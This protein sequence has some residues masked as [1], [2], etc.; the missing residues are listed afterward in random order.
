[1]LTLSRSLNISLGSYSIYPG[2]CRPIIM[3]CLADARFSI[4]HRKQ[5]SASDFSRTLRSLG[6]TP[7]AVSR[8]L[9]SPSHQEFIMYVRGIFTTVGLDSVVRNMLQIVHLNCT[10]C[11][12]YS[13]MAY[14][15]VNCTIPRQ[16]SRTCI[17]PRQEKCATRKSSG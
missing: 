8:A 10:F 4:Y 14:I 16:S 11:S 7:S 1:M 2:T 17:S 3:A 5:F 12:L 15:W 9:F 6:L 13:N